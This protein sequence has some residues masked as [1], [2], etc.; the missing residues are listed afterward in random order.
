VSLPTLAGVAATSP[1][2]LRRG[3]RCVV[4]AAL[5]PPPPSTEW[6]AHRSET[7][8]LPPSGECQPPG[9]RTRPGK[10]RR[11]GA[12]QEGESESTTTCVRVS[13][14]GQAVA[15]HHGA[16]RPSE[17]KPPNHT[18]TRSSR[19][20]CWAAAATL[21]TPSRKRPCSPCCL[22]GVGAVRGR[23]PRARLWRGAP[24][25]SDHDVRPAPREGH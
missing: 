13:S 1:P 5:T 22:H 8:R 24:V 15:A 19:K 9:G 12:A 25:P 16:P 23:H 17:T 10:A 6:R 18:A 3:Q 2:L 4:A 21:A 20:A 7:A 14:S 11:A